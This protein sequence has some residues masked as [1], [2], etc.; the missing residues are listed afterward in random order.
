MIQA[1]LRTQQMTLKSSNSSTSWCS[2]RCS[3]GSRRRSLRRAAFRHEG[4]EEGAA[5]PLR[6]VLVEERVELASRSHLFERPVDEPGHRAAHCRVE[7]RVVS[8][9]GGQQGRA[10]AGEA[11]DEVERS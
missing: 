8:E 2:L 9:N 6:L 3:A 7:A 5:D 1:G 11:G 10:A 4:F